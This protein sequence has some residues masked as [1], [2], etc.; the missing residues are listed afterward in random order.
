LPCRSRRFHGLLR[1]QSRRKSA[2]SDRAIAALEEGFSGKDAPKF[3][4]RAEYEDEV[5]HF[6]SIIVGY[7]DDLATYQNWQGAKPSDWWHPGASLN[8]E[9]GF[10]RECYTPGVEDTETT[11]GHTYPE[12]Y[13]KIADRMSGATDTHLYWGSARDRIPRSQTDALEPVGQPKAASIDDKIA[14]P[15]IHIW[16]SRENLCLLRS[17]QDWSVTDDAE[18]NSI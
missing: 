15:E 13:S 7:W 11:F 4:D 17:G 6:N 2:E 10:F 18:Q 8:G 9:L 12:G 3:W 5:G 16:S 1:V 14:T